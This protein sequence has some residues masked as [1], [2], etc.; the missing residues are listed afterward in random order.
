MPVF[1]ALLLSNGDRRHVHADGDPTSAIER[2]AHS[3]KRS[4]IETVEGA[5]VNPDHIVTAELIDLPDTPAAVA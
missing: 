1:I 4:W 3:G 2:W 5:W